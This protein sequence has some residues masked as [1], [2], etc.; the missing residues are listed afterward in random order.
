MGHTVQISYDFLEQCFKNVTKVRTI[1]STLFIYDNHIYDNR[2]SNYD[3]RKKNIITSICH[4]RFEK[5][6]IF[7]I[8][9][10]RL[11]QTSKN[12]CCHRLNKDV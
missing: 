1:F 10:A 11:G 4:D 5:D 3:G 2:K 6:I 8:L 7:Q 12:S 9:N